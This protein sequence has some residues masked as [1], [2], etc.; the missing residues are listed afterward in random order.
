MTMQLREIRIQ[1]VPELTRQEKFNGR[2]YLVVPVIAL[3]ESVLQGAN[4][5]SPEYCPAD[6]LQQMPG[7]WNGRPIV[8]NH[9]QVQGAFVSANS[10]QILEDWS[11][12]SIFNSYYEDGALKLEAWLDI[13]VAQEKGGDFQD[14]IDRVNAGEVIEVSTGLFCDVIPGNGSFRGQRYTAKWSNINSDHL[15]MLSAGVQGACSVENGCGAPRLNVQNEM[16]VKVQST[17]ESCPCGG[18]DPVACTCEGAQNTQNT[19]ATGSTIVANKVPSGMLMGNARQVLNDACKAKFN[20][21]TYVYLIDASADYAVVQVYNDEWEGSAYQISYKMDDAGNVKFTGDPEPVMLMTTVM[22]KPTVS[23]AGVTPTA[24]TTVSQTEGANMTKVNNTDPAQTAAIVDP[25]ATVVIADVQGDISAVTATTIPSPGSVLATNATGT[26][27]PTME[28]YL[29]SMPPEIRK[30]FEGALKT[31]AD[32][33]SQLISTIK[34]NASNKFSDLVLNGMDVEVLEG[35]AAIAEVTAQAPMV[36]NSGAPLA[37]AVFAGRAGVPFD[38]SHAE[39]LNG[40]E[41]RNNA[42]ADTTVFGAPPAPRMNT[43]RVVT[44]VARPGIFKH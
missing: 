25:S 34:A 38:G 6:A 8:M 44:E 24:D 21:A 4:A 16:K 29:S 11:F 31:Q 27:T 19:Q 17:D 26:P 13:Q 15:A 41:S 42:S 18:S 40:G 22:P 39:L 20:D 37:P 30:M 14:V 35:I 2:D 10:P 7:K 23:E 28:S 5:A 12:G 36:V 32:R 1:S 9:P 3:R 43:Q 33:K